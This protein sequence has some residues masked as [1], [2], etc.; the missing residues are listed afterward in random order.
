MQQVLIYMAHTGA[1]V[2]QEL[3]E[4]LSASYMPGDSAAE[5]SVALRLLSVNQNLMNEFEGVMNAVGADIRAQD[6]LR[7]I[8]LDN[9]PARWATTLSPEELV[10]VAGPIRNG[11]VV[12]RFFAELGDVP[13]DIE[14]NYPDGKLFHVQHG[15][16]TQA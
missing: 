1:D 3:A 14:Q 12:A 7:T 4:A 10:F 2:S 5:A 6:D 11:N 13:A 16:P 8:R 9:W 15:I